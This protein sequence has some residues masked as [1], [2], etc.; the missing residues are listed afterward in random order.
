MEDLEI[1]SLYWRR[2]ETAI[3]E[4]DRKYGPFC[5][6]IALNILSSHQDSEECVNDT[7]QK[8]WETIPPTKPDSL[9]AY[10]GR[11]VRNLSISRYRT[12]HAQK[13]FSGMEVLLSE[14]E[15]CVPV[16]DQIH[17]QVEAEEL[18]RL[19]SSWLRGLP[20]DDRAIFLRRYWNGEA[21]KELAR[22]AGLRPNAMTKRLLRLR[23]DLRRY[24][25]GKGIAV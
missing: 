9:R 12:H 18:G 21:V 2:D 6:R 15:D 11:I 3:T 20:E 19:I 16:P 10:L 1:I 24:L 22:D 14:L 23:E 17:Q 5:H 4:T 13:R 25:E 7:Y 8:T